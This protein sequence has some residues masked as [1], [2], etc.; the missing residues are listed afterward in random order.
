MTTMR[1]SAALL[2]VAAAVLAAVRAE[3][4]Y[5]FFDWK[6]T[7]GT[8]TIMDVAQKVMLINDMFPGP[9]INCSSN[10]NI[11]VNVFNQ[12]DHPLLFNWH[13]IQQRKN[14]WMDGMPGTNCPIQPGTNWTY[15]WQPKDQIGTF[16]YFP[17]MGM[18]RAAGGYGIITVHSRLLIP[19]PFDE[20]AGDYPVLVGDWYTKDHTVLAKNLDA[21]K[22]IG[23]PAGLVING[24]NEKDASNPPMY[25][26]EAGKVYR[27]R[28]CNVGIKT[29]LNVRIQGH[30]LKLVEME[31]SHTVQNSYDSL[32]VHVAQC[33]SF[34]VTAD[35]KPGDYL[36]VASTRFLKEYSAIT[37]IVRYNGSNTPASPKLPEGPSGWA[38]SINQWRSFRWNLTASAARPNPQGSY[39]YGQINI[40]RTIKLCTSKGKVD[41]KERFALNGVSHV[42]DAQTPLKLAEYFNASSGVFEYNLIGDVP[43]A[44]TVPQ[45]LAP[46]VISAEFRTFIEVVFENPEKS[47]DS[48]H[49]NGYA[50]FAAGMGPGIWTPECRKTY[51]LLD[52][53][54]RHTIQVYPR[55]WTAVMLTFDNA[56]MWNIRSNMWERYYLGAQLYVSVVS[57]ARSL[58]DEYNMPEIALRCGKVVGLPMPP[59]YLPA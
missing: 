49:I 7:Y 37:A 52:T 25:T 41:G 10:N 42:D 4:P 6:V 50:F 28:V 22:S 21:G 11:V 45:K 5:H 33:V 17:S 23:R 2:L 53:V 40:T 56:G 27:F 13:G 24:K 34:L 20:P 8:R 35:Q 14:S 47:I 59:S 39:H 46:N 51:N 43:P 57:P 55:S 9:T 48:F 58:R 12:L 38:W 31:G 18:Q 36:L 32:D 29:S 3:D 26:M 30:S 15:K 54:S 44:T 16:F 19:V 1:A